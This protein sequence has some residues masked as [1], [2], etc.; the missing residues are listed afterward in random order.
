[1]RSP[2][3]VQSHSDGRPVRWHV[4]RTVTLA[5]PIIVSRAGLIVLFTVDTFMAGQAGGL[6]LAGLGLGVAPLLTVLLVSMGALQAAVVLAAQAIGRGEPNRVGDTFRAGLVNAAMLGVLTGL[7]ALLAEPFFLLTGQDPAVAAVA[8]GV[9]VQFGWGL[10]GQLL[11]LTANMMLEATD[12]PWAGMV[13]MLVAN[14]ANILLD[15]VF[16]LGWGGLVETGG[17]ATAMATS[18]VVRWFTFLA[19]I[20]VLLAG[21]ARDGD[22]FGF[23]ANRRRWLA[24]V[25]A[26]GGAEGRAIRRLGLPMGL[27]QGVESAAF[28]SLVFFA[29]LIGTAALAA[30]QTTMTVMSLVYMNAVGLGGA[31]SIRVGN[32]VGRRAPRDLARA[33]WSAIGL[34]AV[35]SGVF[36]FAM[37]AFPGEIA[38]LIV[39][40]PA[41][42]A[43]STGTLRLAGY[44][45]A[46]DAMMGVA[47]GALRGVGDV[48]M[49]LWLQSAA[50]WFVAVPVAWLSSIVLE[51]GAIG[52]F[53]GIGAGIVA[54]LALLL[55]R[56]HLV[57]KRAG[58]RLASAALP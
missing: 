20:S 21:A 34:G 53:V 47:M 17:A 27:G 32:A 41:A 58:R 19:A 35:F 11:F 13:I 1:L 5:W 56:F 9:A 40:D 31:A 14:L 24:S 3:P 6:E 30:H 16:V 49:P 18:S 45:V 50:F 51:H 38:A 52:L 12:R 25:L 44:L 57:A 15:G 36:G 42:V 10:P 22:R 43:V 4:Q 46:L 37:M 48:W 2:D 29:G 33:G 39:D 7:L 55:P 54:S 23:L 26:L 28:A 8:A